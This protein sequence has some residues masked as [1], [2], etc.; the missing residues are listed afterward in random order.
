MSPVV[1]VD[2]EAPPDAADQVD[3][4][5]YVFSDEQ[6][7]EANKVQDQ[8]VQHLDVTENGP[9]EQDSTVVPIVFPQQ[10][11]YNVNFATDEVLTQI[12]NSYSDQFY[13]PFTGPASLNPGISGLMKMAVSDLFEDY[14][15]VG[16]FRLALDLNN[17]DYMVSYADL[18]R[19]LDK[20][21]TFQRQAL[22]GVSAL[23]VV[24]L[25]THQA[26]YQL[27]Y[28]FTELT[29]LRGSVMYRNDRYVVQSTD[30]LSLRYPNFYDQ[31]VGVRLEYVFDS[32]IPRGLN[33]YTGLE[34]E[35]LWRALRRSRTV[36]PPR[37]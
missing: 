26:S 4:R 35:A 15:I 18:R 29:A 3:I 17:N 31:M 2:P 28:P 36:Q 32:S 9:V 23:G 19:R 11:N 24:K 37:R 6:G 30:L 21:F 33:L 16:G 14:K 34:T 20:K 10:R 8:Q 1:K 5:N 27:S 12:D 7:K 13:Q 22:Q 25:V